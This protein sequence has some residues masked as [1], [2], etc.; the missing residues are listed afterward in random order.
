MRFPGAIEDFEDSQREALRKG[1][2]G[3]QRSL[4]DSEIISRGDMD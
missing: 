1:P 2:R 4:R 3:M